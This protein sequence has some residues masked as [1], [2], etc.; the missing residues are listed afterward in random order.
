MPDI[1]GIVGTNGLFVGIETKTETGDLSEAQCLWH[2]AAIERG[3]VVIVA[4]PS[5]FAEV[6]RRVYFLAGGDF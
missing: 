1:C 6:V 5:D 4:R 2:Q 3:A